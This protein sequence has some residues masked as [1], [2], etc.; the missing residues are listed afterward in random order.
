MESLLA[1]IPTEE[2]QVT[3]ERLDRLEHWLEKGERMLPWAL[4]FPVR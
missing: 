2:R 3:K 1:E 4:S